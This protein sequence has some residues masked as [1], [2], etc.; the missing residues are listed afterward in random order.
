[1]SYNGHTMLQFTTTVDC[2]LVRF[3]FEGLKLRTDAHDI[4]GEGWSGR[5]LQESLNRG[6]F[7]VWADTIGTQR[8]EAGPPSWCDPPLS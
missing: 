4:L 6:L 3:A 2:T 8:D 1:M 5:K 7:Y